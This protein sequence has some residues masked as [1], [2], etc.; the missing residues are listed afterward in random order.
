[1]LIVPREAAA[2][3]AA[4][5]GTEDEIEVLS[6]CSE[7]VDGEPFALWG[8]PA[9]EKPEVASA[10]AGQTAV[11]A[12]PGGRCGD[13]ALAPARPLG[14]GVAANAGILP[15]P[16]RSHGTRLRCPGAFHFVRAADPDRFPQCIVSPVVDYHHARA[17]R[18]R[19]AIPHRGSGVRPSRVPSHPANVG[20]F[21]REPPVRRHSFSA[22]PSIYRTRAQVQR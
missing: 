6:Q 15:D 8:E 13:V 1:M 9:P 3:L 22:P 11:G 2:Q 21:R 10:V 18:F 14:G 16:A 7:Y 12:D 20:L 19:F 4:S 17:V 5:K